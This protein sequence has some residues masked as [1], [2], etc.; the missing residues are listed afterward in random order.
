MKI[1]KLLVG[2][3]VG[4]FVLA[5]QA[6]AATFNLDFS[7]PTSVTSVPTADT[8]TGTVF[9]GVTGDIFGVRVAPIS[10]SDYT[11]VTGS[12]S[13][14]YDLATASNSLSFLWGS[15]DTFNTVY[16]INTVT[17]SFETI[18]GTDLINAGATAS[19]GFAQIAISSLLSFNQVLFTSSQNSFE[20]TN[21]V[22]TAVPLPAAL[23]LYG[24][25]IAL[26][27]FMGRRRKK[28]MS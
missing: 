28:A 6:S 2:A 27:A 10:G 11:A 4:V 18:T 21:M 22:V 20:F 24:A 17:N 9:Q 8:T 16:L 5:Q 26:L 23:P 3:F 1:L 25:G 14:T 12:S 15:V 19:S 13:A 7:A